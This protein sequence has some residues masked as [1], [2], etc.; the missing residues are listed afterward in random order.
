[1]MKNKTNVQTLL[2]HTD[3]R[4]DVGS[5]TKKTDSSHN[6]KWV[7]PAYPLL[8]L[9]YLFVKLLNYFPTPIHYPHC[10]P[11]P[12]HHYRPPAYLPSQV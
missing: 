11:H 5:D 4:V 8:A 12:Y 7:L 9:L 3:P 6:D 2:K 10:H 1:M